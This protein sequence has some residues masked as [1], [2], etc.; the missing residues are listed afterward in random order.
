MNIEQRFEQYE[1]EYLN[2]RVDP[3]LLYKRHDVIV[4]NVI[5]NLIPAQNECSPDLIVS[6]SRDEIF[7]GIDAEKF[8]DIVTDDQLILLIRCGLRYDGGRGCLC[9]FV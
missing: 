4:I 8:S 3:N 6:A 5:D 9:M 2:Y 7:F 1:D